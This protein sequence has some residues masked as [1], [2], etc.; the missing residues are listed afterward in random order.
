[1]SL[2]VAVQMDPI[3]AVDID[4]DSTFR[5]AE[6]AQARGHRLFYYHVDDLAWNEGRVEAAGWDL[7]VRR[8]RGN[9]FSLGE[10]R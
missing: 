6:E 9:H 4:A 1:M 5:L 2:F 8:E 3:G 10:K 7:T